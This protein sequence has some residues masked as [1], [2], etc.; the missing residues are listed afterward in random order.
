[1]NG[2]AL[3][4][5]EEYLLETDLSETEFEFEVKD[6]SINISTDSRGLAIDADSEYRQLI[7]RYEDGDPRLF[8]LWM[9]EIYNEF[10]EIFESYKRE[11]GYRQF[12]FERNDVRDL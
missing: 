12:V 11:N 5:S 3:S 2:P 1:M 10:S 9:D 4:Q 6:T 7:F 8:N